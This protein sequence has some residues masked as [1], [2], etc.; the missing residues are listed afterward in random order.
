MFFFNSFAAIYP[1]GKSP[2]SLQYGRAVMDPRASPDITEK[3][4][5]SSGN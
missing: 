5:I 2:E 3:R 1:Q 4:K